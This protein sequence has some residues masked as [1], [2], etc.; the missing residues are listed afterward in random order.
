MPGRSKTP[1]AQKGF[2]IMLPDAWRRRVLAAGAGGFAWLAVAGCAGPRS[3]WGSKEPSAVKPNTEQSITPSAAV[4]QKPTPDPFPDGRAE[5]TSARVLAFVDRLER[6]EGPSVSMPGRA[7][8]RRRAA[9]HDDPSQDGGNPG[10]APNANDGSLMP[11]TAANRSQSLID[12]PAD[13]SERTPSIPPKLLSVSTVGKPADT[14]NPWEGKTNPRLANAPVEGSGE[15]KET[16]G[17][18]GVIAGLQRRVAESPSDAEAHWKLGMVKLVAG[19]PEAGEQAGGALPADSAT[20]LRRSLASTQ[21][22]RRALVDPVSGM[23]E[24]VTAVEQLRDHLQ[25]RAG[26]A[27]PVVALCSRVQAF[28][29]YDELPEGSFHAGVPNQSI[30][31]L[32]L[33]HF[34]SEPTAD[35]RYRTV[36]TD[37]F[38]VLT[39]AG[40]VLWSHAEPSIEDVSRQRREDFFIAQRILV[41]AKLS[42]GSYVLKV[43]VEDQLA[44]KHTQAVHRFQ[45][46][47]ATK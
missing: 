4:E 24:A 5:D 44:G 31:Y 29:V 12:D 20:L 22:T 17:L 35:G 45:V 25:A 6:A 15:D 21:A 36:L 16:A 14:M 41:P 7:N 11:P 19:R 38:E 3:L 32:E 33:K 18:N 8:P 28:G 1:S 27:V 42:A 13:R 46:T 34:K 10:S 43:T 26:L 40:Q 30:V 2:T 9:D 47:E 37:K 39:P 23:D